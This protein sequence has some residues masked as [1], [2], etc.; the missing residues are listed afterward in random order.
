MLFK[1]TRRFGPAA[2]VASLAG[3]CSS[4]DAGGPECLNLPRPP[5]RDVVELARVFPSVAVDGGVDLQL[6]PTG[7][8]WYVATQAGRIYT[9]PNV[10][11][12][13]APTVFAD[14]S[15]QI[16]VGGEAGLLG[17][18]FHPDY[19]DNRE[20]FLSYTGPGGPVFESRVSRFL[21]GDDGLTLDLASEEPILVVDQPYTNHNGGG[22]GFDRDGYLYFSLGDGG[23]GGDPQGHAQNPDSLLG[24]ILRLDTGGGEPY[25]IPPDNPY[26]GGGGRPE[27]FAL[28]L[29]NPWRFSFDRATG[30]LWAG[31]VGQNVWEEVD[32]IVLGG[33]YGWNIKEGR[34]CFGQ[35]TC[36]GAGLVDPVAQ[37]RNT[38][39]ASV[40]A[41]FVYRGAELPDLAGLFV[42]TDFYGQTLWG[43]RDG[44]A[45]VVLGEA[46]VRGTV[47]FAED[48]AGELYALAYDGGIYRL[49]AASPPTGPG[50]PDMLSE[51]GCLDVADPRRPPAGA[52][53]YEINVPF[54]S[55]GADK[56][57]WMFLPPGRVAT[58]GDDDDLALP[59][60][61]VVVK[62]FELAGAPVETRLFVH[63][64]DGDWAGYSYAWE[65]DGSDARLL[66]GGETRVVGEQTW[67]FPDRADCMYCHSRAAGRTLGLEL[68]QLA[69][70][71]PDEAGEPVDQLFLLG[72][73]GV[74][75]APPDV[76]PLPAID[77]DAPL[78][79]RARAYL[80]ANCSQCHRPDAPSGR[81]R[82]DLRAGVPVGN[83]GLCDAPPRSGDLDLADAALL[84]PGDPARS[85]LSARMHSL[86]STRMPAVG[87]AVVDE[88]GVALIDA[89]ISSLTACPD[90]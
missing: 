52:V 64:G 12:P 20:V 43:V 63:H 49:R 47:A 78:A 33:N 72:A 67:I 60:G 76:A 90:F 58:V 54:W 35:D 87:S 74:L 55:D 19:A 23:S 66:E 42:Y 6:A 38:G 82:I 71:V 86:G 75:P 13:P 32:R 85:I 53:A 28:G 81:A 73:Q 36:A 9:F 39:G 77:G 24:K 89:W 84:T 26:A 5:S 57:R 41:G 50:L 4:G 34:D 45:P 21:A 25:A 44:E 88:A 61:S 29:R 17:M 16:V 1:L 69:R 8:R 80:H 79:D 27:I 48:Q 14:L 59:T 51:T 31:D 37:Y 3:A 40:I 18:A 15:D 22:L 83:M 2:L 11:D 65:Q 62:T 56:T 10:A 30:D 68:A 70:D 7:D 46:G